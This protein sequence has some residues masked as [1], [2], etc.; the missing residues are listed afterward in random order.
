MSDTI[1][2]RIT[3]AREKAGLTKHALS[4]AVECYPATLASW[5]A[6]R[7][8]PR[9]TDVVAVATACGVD[10]GWLLTGDGAA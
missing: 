6:G 7:A 10:A 2:H 3:K 5:E 8:E 4:I 1:G 9:A